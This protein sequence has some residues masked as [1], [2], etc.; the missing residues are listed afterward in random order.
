[1]PPIDSTL[2][3]QDYCYL[4]TV[5]RISG[6]PREIEIWFGLADGVL[7]MLAGGGEQANWVRNLMREPRVSVRVAGERRDGRA[8]LVTDPAEDSRARALVFDKYAQR[9]SG[10]LGSWRREALVVAVD[11]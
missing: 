2:A 11:L 8:R 7:Y 6:E 9:Y 10:D 3:D 4:T 1:V 5:G